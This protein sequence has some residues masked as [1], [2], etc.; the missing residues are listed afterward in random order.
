MLS[1][2]TSD[3]AIPENGSKDGRY[4]R[5]KV[6]MSIN[7][8]LPRGK[9]IKMGSEEKWIEFRYENLPYVCYYC[10]ILGHTERSCVL[11]EEHVRKGNVKRDQ[12][13][14]W[15]RAENHGFVGTNLKRQGN[16]NVRFSVHMNGQGKQVVDCDEGT[17]SN[18]LLLNDNRMETKK[19]NGNNKNP[20]YFAPHHFFN[21]EKKGSLLAGDNSVK[22]NTNST[23]Q[24]TAR[25][26]GNDLK[27]EIVNE[28]LRAG[29]QEGK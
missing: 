20:P 25:M 19:D 15:M 27:Y 7:K 12:F 8:P 5:L 9:L 1:V 11:R 28:P 14:I 17:G 3:V 6:L 24:G 4:I 21:R 16:Q 13:G 23:V 2:E 26:I 10:G 22:Q 29:H 18:D